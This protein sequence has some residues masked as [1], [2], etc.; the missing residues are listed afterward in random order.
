MIRARFIVALEDYRPVTWPIKRPYWCSGYRASDD[1]AILVA[2][3]DSV[4]E[5]QELWPEAEHI[6][7]LEDGLDKYTFTERFPAS[8]VRGSISG[9]EIPCG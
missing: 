1:A 5:I 9:E 6:D 7:I 8:R 2:Y 3:A 4:D